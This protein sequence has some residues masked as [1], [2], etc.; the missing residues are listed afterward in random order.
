MSFDE[1]MGAEALAAV[2]A[3][4]SGPGCWIWGSCDEVGG[5]EV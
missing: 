5:G 4:D 2:S 1:G 3:A